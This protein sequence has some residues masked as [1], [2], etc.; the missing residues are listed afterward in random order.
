MVF[1]FGSELRSGLWWWTAHHEEWKDDVGCAGLALP[2]G[3]AVLIDPLIPEESWLER[4]EG[5]IHVLVTLYW[6]AR[7]ARLLAERL[8]ARVWSSRRGATALRRR[9]PVSDTFVPGQELPGGVVPYA[10]ARGSEVVFWLPEQRALFA[11]DALLWRD[12][13][14][15][16]CP[17]SWLPRGRTRQELAQS[18]KPLLELPVELLLISHRQVVSA[19][20]RGQLKRALSGV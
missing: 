18:L 17:Q 4:L 10:A 2:D 5:D 9:A 16:L 1:V 7:S 8:G 13:G 3:G 12:S 14:L 11:G 19:D 20:A 6:H 15:E